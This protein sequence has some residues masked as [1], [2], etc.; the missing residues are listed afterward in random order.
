MPYNIAQ[1]QVRKFAK[2]LQPKRCIF[3]L[4]LLQLVAIVSTDRN[5]LTA[6][7]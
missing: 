1:V 6:E 3:L 7:S 2:V 5:V 4:H